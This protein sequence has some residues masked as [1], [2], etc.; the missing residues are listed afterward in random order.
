LTQICVFVTNKLFEI[1]LDNAKKLFF[2][3]VAATEP[4]IGALSVIR[5]TP[6]F[7]GLITKL[8]VKEN[9]RSSCRNKTA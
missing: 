9:A 3:G 2:E 1:T 5:S 7:Q 4:K 8:K 6:N